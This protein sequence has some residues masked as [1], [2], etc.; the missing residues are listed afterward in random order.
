MGAVSYSREFVIS[1]ILDIQLN[2]I[3]A[4]YEARAKTYI[5]QAD[6]TPLVTTRSS[7]FTV[8]PGRKARDDMTWCI[9]WFHLAQG[10]RKVRQ[11]LKRAIEILIAL[12][13]EGKRWSRWVSEEGSEVNE[14]TM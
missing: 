5:I 8:L 14:L 2:Q 13:R 10:R 1:P 3:Y 12:Y 4:S 6:G 9:P 11:T 7:P